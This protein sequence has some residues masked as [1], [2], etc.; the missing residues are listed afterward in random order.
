MLDKFRDNTTYETK[1][2][3]QTWETGRMPRIRLGTIHLADRAKLAYCL[4]KYRGYPR[5]ENLT[6]ML[7]LEVDY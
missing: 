5:E 7:A 6:G 1:Q 3:L 4:D 2:L